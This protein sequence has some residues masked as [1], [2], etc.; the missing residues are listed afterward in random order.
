MSMR[1]ITRAVRG[2]AAVIATGALVTGLGAAPAGAAAPRD[3]RLKV[4]TADAEAVETQSPRPAGLL[5]ESGIQVDHNDIVDVVRNGSVV[6]SHERRV[7]KNGDLVKVVRVSHRAK[8]HTVR[9][10]WRHT[11]TRT[12]ASLPP[13]KRK[14]AHPGRDGVRRI[15]V[16]VELHNGRPVDRDV[17]QRWVRKPHPRVILVGSRLNWDALAQ[18]ES[19]GNPRAVNPAGYYG[20]YQFSVSTWRSVGGSGMP[21]HASPGEQ[22]HRAQILYSRSGRSPWPN[23]GRYL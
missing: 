20:L 4:G 10:D 16:R 6:Q 13:G 3:V 9:L 22:T 7:L 17:H 8:V 18:C 5:E 11:R 1:A 21:H 15:H 23:C 2:G 19:G 12:V 14:V